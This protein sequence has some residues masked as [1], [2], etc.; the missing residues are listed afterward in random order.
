MDLVQV[1]F[2]PGLD[3]E[4]VLPSALAEALAAR[5]ARVVAR[6][7]QMLIAQGSDADEV[8]V[9]Q[10]GRVAVSV[11]SANGRE[12]HLRDMGPGRLLGEIAAMSGLPRSAC[13]VVTEDATL[14]LVSAAVF[15]DFLR[16]VPGA[17]LWMATQ[18]VSRVRN[19]TEKSSELA[20]L[21]VSARI[22]S[23][24]LRLA[25]GARDGDACVIVSLPTHAEL[26]SRIGTHREAVTRE[27]RQLAREG[28]VSQAGRRLEIHSLPRL[29]AALERLSQ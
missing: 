29:V 5:A 3:V 17:G 9:I 4:E 24:L 1:G 21:P 23:E 25:A 19:L 27:L 18:L 7:G 14:A 20:S 11:F 6:K 8:Y 22:V 2:V 15:R 16:D 12:I 10:S 28:L 13:V 26:A